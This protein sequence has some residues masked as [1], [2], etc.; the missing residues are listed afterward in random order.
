MASMGILRTKA[1]AALAVLVVALTACETPPPV[2]SFPDLTYGHHGQM[3]L[4]VASLEVVSEYRSP[5]AKPHVEHLFPVSSEKALRQWAADRLKPDG[6]EGVARFV[7]I[8]A[9]VTE[10]VLKKDETFKGKFTTQQTERY[11]AVIEATLEIKTAQGSGHAAAR[12]SRSITVPED[13]SLNDREQEWFNLVEALTNDFNREMEKQI[14][15]HLVNW[16]K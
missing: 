6:L 15:Q 16:L 9:P 12:V 3:R 2:L 10:T 4:N 8:D 5:M 11:E 7:I 1:I 13:A 14:R